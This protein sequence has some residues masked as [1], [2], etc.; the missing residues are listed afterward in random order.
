[1]PQPG[2]PFY[3]FFGAWRKCLLRQ[4]LGARQAGAGGGPCHKC[5]EPKILC[6]PFVPVAHV[7]ISH[8]IASVVNSQRCIGILMRSHQNASHDVTSHRHIKSHCLT[9]PNI[10]SSPNQAG[11]LAA[12][13]RPV[14]YRFWSLAGVPAAA[15]A[16]RQA[17]RGRRGPLPQVLRTKDPLQTFCARCACHHLASHCECCQLATLHWNTH[18][19]EQ[20]RIT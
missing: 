18:V 7:T 19:I 2:R 9:D 6:K 16:G 4:A 17:G 10:S 14:S 20:E 3:M 13:R 1:M 8:H 15:G 12:A 5:Y 11:S